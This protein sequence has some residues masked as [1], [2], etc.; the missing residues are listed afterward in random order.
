MSFTRRPGSA[1]STDLSSRRPP[2]HKKWVCTVNCF[3]G[4]HPVTRSTFT[5]DPVSSR[6]IRM[7][8]GERHWGSW[9]PLCVP[10]FTPTH[11]RLHLEW[12][13]ARGNWTAAER[14]QVIFSEESRF[15][16]S[17]DDNRV[18]VWRP[19]GERL[20]PA[21][22]LQRQTAP[23]IGVMVWGAIAYNTQ[24]PLVLIRGTITAQRVYNSVCLVAKQ[25]IFGLKKFLMR[26]DFF[27]HRYVEAKAKSRIQA[28]IARRSWL[29]HRSRHVTSSRP[30][31]IDDPSCVG[32]LIYVKSVQ[33]QSHLVGVMWW[34][35]EAVTA[36]DSV[37]KEKS[38]EDTA[39]Q[40]FSEVQR[41]QT[42]RRRVAIATASIYLRP[43]FWFFIRDR[44]LPW[45]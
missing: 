36:Q 13:G 5:V 31:A 20:N 24:S 27:A 1:F 3:I 33:S 30:S 44:K 4:R 6:T 23:T 29:R 22:A 17:S 7:H 21:F 15:S 25:L 9:H 45:R 8:L 12:C 11:R 10:P 16:L 39:E 26:K 34:F 32:R 28:A 40:I 2:H 42:T 38:E 19:R 14:N 43:P 35:V 37:Q 41:T 18:R